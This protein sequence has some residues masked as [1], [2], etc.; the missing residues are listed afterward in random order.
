MADYRVVKMSFW[1]DSK[2]FDNFTPE[3]KYFYLYLITNTHTNLCGCYELGFKQMSIETGYTVDVIEKLIS[4]FERT[5]NVIR[6]SKETREVLLINWAKHNWTT[7]EKYLSGVSK[8]INKIKDAEFKHY[9]ECLF[10]G[11]DTVSIPYAYPTDTSISITNNTSISNKDIK[12]IEIIKGIVDYLN[13]KAD[14]NFNYKTSK[15]QGYIR[16][17]LKEGYTLEDFKKVIDTKAAEWKDKPEM[18]KYLR[19]ETLFS[20]SKFEGYL[21][22]KQINSTKFD[23]ILEFMREGNE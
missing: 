4:R 18:E 9:I 7:S 10:N 20:P 11:N 1:T 15:T 6:Y 23:A 13:I 5:H 16:A 14:K 2:V 17:R 21:N 8:D 19:P 3:D 22:Q 12:D